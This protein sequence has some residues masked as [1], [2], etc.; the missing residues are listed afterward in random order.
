MVFNRY[1]L[2]Q[3]VSERWRL[4]NEGKKEK[5]IIEADKIMEY[6]LTDEI[7]FN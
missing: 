5:S 4:K 3:R 7:A 1:H 2:G 6:M